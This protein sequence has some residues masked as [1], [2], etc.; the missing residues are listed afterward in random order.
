MKEE[1]DA[2]ERAS[3]EFAYEQAWQEWAGSEDEALW[4]STIGD[5]LDDE[6][7]PPR[8]EEPADR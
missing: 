1:R 4:E 5:G 3:L 2:Q 8:A 6:A 7:S